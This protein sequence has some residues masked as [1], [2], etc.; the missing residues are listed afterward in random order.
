MKSLKC[1]SNDEKNAVRNITKSEYGILR[2]LPQSLLDEGA[3][4]ELGNQ[5][6]E[7]YDM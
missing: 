6:I 7:P 5:R 1:F 2:V 3:R 4:D